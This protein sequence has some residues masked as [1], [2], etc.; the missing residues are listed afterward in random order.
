MKVSVYFLRLKNFGAT[1]KID[2]LARGCF[3]IIILIFGLKSV[4]LCLHRLDCSFQFG[5]ST[6][7]Y[8]APTSP[9]GSESA[10]L[11]VMSDTFSPCLLAPALAL[12]PS[13]LYVS[14]H[15]YPIVAVLLLE[16]AEP[17]Q[18]ATPHNICNLL[19]TQSPTQLDT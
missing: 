12:W 7:S 6:P 2:A 16:M 14:A 1:N 10:E 15:R 9:E 19:Y 18:S 11:Q 5:S 17:P 13:H 4:V 3:S 8:P